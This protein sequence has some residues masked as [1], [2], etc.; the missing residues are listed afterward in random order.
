MRAL[1]LSRGAPGWVVLLRG[2]GGL[3]VF[4]GGRVGG[5]RGWPCAC[6]V[7]ELGGDEDRQYFVSRSKKVGK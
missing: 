7:G 1:A 6:G 4:V 2:C 3:A 5:L